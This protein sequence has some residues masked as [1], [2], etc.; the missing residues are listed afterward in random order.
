MVA[1]SMASVVVKVGI[2]QSV[3]IYYKQCEIDPFISGGCSSTG[4]VVTNNR[5]LLPSLDMFRY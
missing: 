1:R 5:T 2:Y 3:V 4:C